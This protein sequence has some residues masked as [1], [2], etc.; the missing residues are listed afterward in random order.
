MKGCERRG[1]DSGHTLTQ[2][3]PVG[4]IQTCGRLL[5]QLTTHVRCEKW[6]CELEC[7]AGVH[8]AISPY[9]TA[10]ALDDVTRHDEAK[11]CAGQ[12]A[13]SIPARLLVAIKQLVQSL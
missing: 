11:T 1:E 8:G 10:E 2:R 13:D 9:P 4:R 5:N 12:P 6:N 3:G 7:R